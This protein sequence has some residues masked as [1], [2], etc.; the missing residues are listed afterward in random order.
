MVDGLV[1][2]C[3]DELGEKATLV[4]TGGYCGLI[5]NYLKR[6]FDSINPILT[7]EGLR[8]IYNMNSAPKSI[9]AESIQSYKC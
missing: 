4:A 3:E 7:L 8:L 6:P 1:Q 2:Q 9:M 5:S